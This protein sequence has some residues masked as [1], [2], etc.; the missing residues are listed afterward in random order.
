MGDDG[1]IEMGSVE[2][3]PT[4]EEARLTPNPVIF[5]SINPDVF[6][7]GG[8]IIID[9]EV[10]IDWPCGLFYLSGPNNILSYESGYDRIKTISW[11]ILL[12]MIYVVTSSF[13]SVLFTNLSKSLFVVMFLLSEIIYP[14]VFN[15]ICWSL[16]GIRWSW[17][18]FR[19]PKNRTKDKC[20]CC[21]F[22]NKSYLKIM[23]V[24]ALCD[25]IA[26]VLKVPTIIF[27]D[28]ILVAV[29]SLIYIPVNM[30]MGFLYS[31]KRYRSAHYLGAGEIIVAGVIS[32]LSMAMKDGKSI[33]TNEWDI[34]MF[35]LI[36]LS[37]IVNSFGQNFKEWHMKEQNLDPWCTTSWIGLFQSVMSLPLLFVVYLPVPKY[38]QKFLNTTNTTETVLEMVTPVAWNNLGSYVKFGF[39]CIF[40]DFTHSYPLHLFPNTT[41]SSSDFIDNGIQC[42]GTGTIFM[43]FCVIN[44][45]YNVYGTD[46]LKSTT[47]NITAIV[48]VFTL[49][50]TNFIFSIRTISG[51][52]YRPIQ[53]WDFVAFASAGLGIASFWSQPEIMPRQTM[54]ERSTGT[55]APESV[56]QFSLMINGWFYKCPCFGGDKQYMNVFEVTDE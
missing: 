1:E 52:A 8:G 46:L 32:F 17:Q 20:N 53:I 12:V 30:V 11:A 21:A 41:N 33:K 26:S 47:A 10:P 27:M 15:V 18:M 37:S 23:I 7:A 29:L 19:Q 49:V 13:D 36:L 28:P 43:I 50:T 48:S 42:E 38:T 45:L 22:V 2:K 9:K 56:S 34:L 40:G 51:A 31:K 14:I 44:V 25:T 16:T 6:V 24:S 35:G 5:T 54:V 39:G 4:D 55:K 3:D